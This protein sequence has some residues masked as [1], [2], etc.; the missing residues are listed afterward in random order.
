MKNF[1]KFKCKQENRIRF[2]SIIGLGIGNVEKNRYAQQAS[3][4]G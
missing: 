3:Q 4:Y 2:S 1:R